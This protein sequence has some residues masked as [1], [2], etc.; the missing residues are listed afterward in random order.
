LQEFGPANPFDELVLAL[1]H[2]D[3]LVLEQLVPR[4]QGQHQERDDAGQ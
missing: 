4:S 2:P 1:P 3:A